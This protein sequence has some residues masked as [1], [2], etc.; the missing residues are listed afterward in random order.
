V[1]SDGRIF[2]D[3]DGEAFGDILR[4]LR[5]G[6][7]FLSGLLRNYS[8]SPSRQGGS[9]LNQMAMRASG[10]NSNLGSIMSNDNNRDRLR[11]LRIEAD[12]YGLHQ[13]VHD[14]DVVTVGEKVILEAKF[15][16][17]RVSGGCNLPRNQEVDA[18]GDGVVVNEQGGANNDQNN[19]QEE[20]QEENE[21]EIME[22]N[23]E[24][25][26]A[27]DEEAEEE[28]EAA[29]DEELEDDIDPNEQLKYKHWTWS[30][31]DG[32]PDILMPHPTHEHSMICGQDGS[33]LLLLRLAAA[34]PSPL[35]RIRWDEAE[36]EGRRVTRGAS[37]R[38]NSNRR[39]R[40]AS[41]TS[42][43]D[44]SVEDDMND[45]S[46][47]KELEEDY[48]VT[49]NIEAPLQTVID[50]V[51]ES[52]THFPLVRTGLWDY[53]TEEEVTNEDP[54]FA[55]FTAM[56]VVSLRAGDILSVSFVNEEISRER[57]P[58]PDN[59]PP[60]LVNSITLVKIYGNTLARY[61]RLK[62]HPNGGIPDSLMDQKRRGSA[63]NAG[64]RGILSPGKGSKTRSPKRSQSSLFSNSQNS[65]MSDHSHRHEED[66]QMSQLECEAEEFD[67][68]LTSTAHWTNPRN[69]FMPTP[70][71]LS[72]KECQSV[73]EF[74]NPGHYLLLGRVALGCRRDA[75]FLSVLSGGPIEG[76]RAQ[77]SI[78]SVGGRL[79]HALGFVFEEKP[80][81]EWADLSILSENANF[82]D[83][84]HIPNAGTE[85]SIT[86][87]G[88]CRLHP[89][90]TEVGPFCN[91]VSQSLSCLLLDDDVMEIDRYMLGTVRNP[92]QNQREIKWFHTRS[93][94]APTGQGKLVS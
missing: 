29:D 33:Y 30:K 74:P 48:F 73:M 36:E 91:V 86:T 39:S 8:S 47:N 58:F 42:D 1:D 46:E 94:S 61:E 7:D 49:V 32:N 83:I 64:L 14:I 6:A 68:S 66:H 81:L 67:R 55:T 71:N 50:S 79:L 44:T 52:Q 89:E 37:R 70:F 34:L 27:E 90:G 78:R 80:R 10:S 72:L 45:L 25:E 31:Q 57:A 17:A 69:D 26:E 60:E 41:T 54:V 23:E 5:G 40:A 35:A 87:T 15:G 38:Q 12:Y 77:M 92:P 9:T 76:H 43:E 11:R 18:N 63:N 2:I 82:N 4:Y 65:Q 13:L 85:L 88:D 59:C 51:D 53:R 93:A 62:S 20:Q 28:E 21:D 3:R 75:T 84:V 22:D 24:E 16:W 56:E 19:Q